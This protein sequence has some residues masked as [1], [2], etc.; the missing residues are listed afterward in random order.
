M[1]LFLIYFGLI[2]V[3]VYLVTQFVMT[4][5]NQKGISKQNVEE[6]SVVESWKNYLE[7]RDFKILSGT[8]QGT[9]IPKALL[10]AE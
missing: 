5:T 4:L 8:F 2:S 1:W 6:K 9:W 7:I 10:N 3:E